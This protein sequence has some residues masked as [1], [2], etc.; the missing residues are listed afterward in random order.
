MTYQFT[1]IDLFAGVGGFRFAL[2][3]LGGKC[4]F[5]S[6]IDKYA[7][8]TY[9]ANF[10]ETPFG[11]IT[12]PEIKSYIPSS[13]DVLCAGF[14][15]QA[16]SI[17]GY[18][19]GFLDVRGTLFFDIA[20]IVKKHRPKVI[21]LE[22][23]KNLISHDKG[24]TLQ[25]ILRILEQELK[26]KVH[27]QVLNSMIHANIAQNR[28]RIFMVAFDSK[29]VVNWHKFAFPKSV[30]LTTN[31]YDFLEHT[32]QEDIFYYAKN[33]KYYAQLDKAITKT[34]TIYQ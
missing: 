7:Q 23:V 15:C 4:V 1:F 9:L 27:Y 13:F 26:Y 5:S 19:K 31:I 17:A 3:K 30:P 10:G 6:E 22:N 29:Q 21:L 28:E 34:D 24:N 18:R 16:F 12:L 32:K 25:T 11:D 2:Q 8:Q 14:P 33:H 20:Q